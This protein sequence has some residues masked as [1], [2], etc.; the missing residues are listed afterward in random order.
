MN[1]K[2]KFRHGIPRCG[3]CLLSIAIVPKSG[4]LCVYYDNHDYSTYSI[5]SRKWTFHS[6]APLSKREKQILI[7]NQEGLTNKEMAYRLHFTVKV[8]EKIKT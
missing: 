2:P 7:L 3:I 5:V 1:L 8:V 6:F 4:N